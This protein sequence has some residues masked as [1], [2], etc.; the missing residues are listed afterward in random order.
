MKAGRVARPVPGGLVD[1]CDT[2]NDSDCPQDERPN[3]PRGQ[4]PP[5][6][7]S[8]RKTSRAP[9]PMPPTIS[10]PVSQWGVTEATMPQMI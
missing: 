6:P 8:H 4:P 9:S 1:S 10:P 2:L 5:V 7:A 3:L